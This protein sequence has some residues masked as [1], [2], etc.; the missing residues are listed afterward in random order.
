LN[1][2]ILFSSISPDYER[3]LKEELFGCFKHIKIPFEEL[4]KMPIRDRKYYIHKYNEYMT[5]R[6]NAMNHSSST[7]DISQY[8][9]MSQGV[10]GDEIFE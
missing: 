4:L 3:I 1:G 6:E 7:T 10:T 8:T 5:A 2:T 9:N